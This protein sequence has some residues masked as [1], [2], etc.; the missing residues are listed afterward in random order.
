MSFLFGGGSKQTSQTQILCKKM[1]IVTSEHV[2]E[3]QWDI[4]MDITDALNN[5]TNRAKRVLAHLKRILEK[6]I[7]N[8]INYDILF[9]I[10]LFFH[11][12]LHS[13]RLTSSLKSVIIEV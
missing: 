5:D 10:R 1:D 6:A 7:S 13:F 4:I 11:H 3:I 9:G 12:S 2:E 8:F